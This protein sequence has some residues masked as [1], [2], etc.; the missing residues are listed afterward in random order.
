MKVAFVN[1]LYRC[2]HQFRNVCRKMNFY[3]VH[4]LSMSCTR[5]HARLNNFPGNKLCGIHKYT[6][7]FY[8]IV[9]ISD[10]NYHNMVKKVLY[11]SVYHI[12][13][14]L[15]NSE[16]LHEITDHVHEMLSVCAV[17][18]IMVYIMVH[19]MLSVCAP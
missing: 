1:I 13:Y 11:T 6:V 18:T 14:Y 10:A 8:H 3:G 7:F 15:G 16:A 4:T 17:C 19:I 5:S 12:V 2:D 9:I